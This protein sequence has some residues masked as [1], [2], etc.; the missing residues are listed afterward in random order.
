MK[1][2]GIFPMAKRLLSILMASLIMLVGFAFAEEDATGHSPVV[3]LYNND[4]HCGI[5][6]AIGYAGLAAYKNAYIKA[7]YDVTLV[8]C[9][10]AI[11]GAAIGTLSEGSYLVDIMNEIGYEVATIGNHE[12]DYGMDRF[13]ELAESAEYTYVAANFTDMDGNTIFDPYTILELGT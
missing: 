8:D 13:L 11:Q 3:I 1:K 6:D 12:F 2:G 9:G 10:D 4:V 5:D 7:G